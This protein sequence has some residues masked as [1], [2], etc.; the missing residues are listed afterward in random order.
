MISIYRR[1][2]LTAVL[3]IVPA[4]AWSQAAKPASAKG[5]WEPVSY[6]EDLEL[7]DVAFVTP[8]VGWV[9]GDKGT[10]LHTKDGG[11]TWDAQ[12]GGDPAAADPEIERAPILRRAARLGHQGQEIAGHDGR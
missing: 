11:K 4:S 2:V 8:D 5:V 6:T 10:I 9:S 3:L 12:L 1:A 7:T